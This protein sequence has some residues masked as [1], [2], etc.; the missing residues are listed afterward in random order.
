MSSMKGR[1]ADIMSQG[2]DGAAQSAHP[3]FPPELVVDVVLCPGPGRH[4]G[5]HPLHAP[6]QKTLLSVFLAGF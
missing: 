4:E 1:P 2:Q 6:L 5:N 3:H